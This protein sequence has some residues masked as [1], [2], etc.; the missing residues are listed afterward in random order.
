LRRQTGGW[1]LDLLVLLGTIKMPLQPS[2]PGA[3]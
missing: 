1:L 2:V 3:E